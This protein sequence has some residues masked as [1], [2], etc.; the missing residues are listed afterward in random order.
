MAGLQASHW[1]RATTWP[2]IW[3]HAHQSDYQRIAMLQP[4]WE[5]ANQRGCPERVAQGGCAAALRG[6]AWE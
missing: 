2:L 3:H 1:L 4:G 5:G 6:C